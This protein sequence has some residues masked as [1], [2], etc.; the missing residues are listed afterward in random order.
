MKKKQ[1]TRDYVVSVPVTGTAEVRITTTSTNLAREIASKRVT[2]NFFYDVADDLRFSFHDCGPCCVKHNQV[3]LE[4]EDW[5]SSDG[6]KRLW[7]RVKDKR[8]ALYVAEVGPSRWMWAWEHLSEDGHYLFG[9]ESDHSFLTKEAAM[10]SL[11][12][13][14][15]KEIKGC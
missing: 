10:K 9:E 1:K 3:G 2:E 12:E 11:V 13:S 5:K 7:T 15:N 14:V 8:F 6:G 4:L